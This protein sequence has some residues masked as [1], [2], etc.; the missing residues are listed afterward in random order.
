MRDTLGINE[1]KIILRQQSSVGLSGTRLTQRKSWFWYL[2]TN[3]DLKRIDQQRL[4]VLAFHFDHGELM[5]VNGEDES[6]VARDR[7]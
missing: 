4:N 1:E 2:R 7:Y 3:K 5:A 6:W